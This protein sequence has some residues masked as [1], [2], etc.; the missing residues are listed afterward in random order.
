MHFKRIDV[1]KVHIQ[2]S[3]E[4]STQEMDNKLFHE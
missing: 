1:S 3:T 4:L 2:L